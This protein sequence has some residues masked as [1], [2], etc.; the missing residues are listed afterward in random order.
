[1]LKEKWVL[2]LIRRAMKVKKGGI[3][4]ITEEGWRGLRKKELE[5]IIKTTAE[6]EA[7]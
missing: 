7:F 3:M 4:E 6:R 2:H 1:M 5:T